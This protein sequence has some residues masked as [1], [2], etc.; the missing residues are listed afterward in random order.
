MEVQWRLVK[1]YA[2]VGYFTV[3]P[4]SF[5]EQ[6][7]KFGKDLEF[8]DRGDQVTWSFSVQKCRN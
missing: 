2:Q 4:K 1:N 7:F 6:H 8:A 5:D 3:D